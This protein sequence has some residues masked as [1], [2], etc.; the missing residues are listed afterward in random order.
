MRTYPKKKGSEAE[1]HIF[2]SGASSSERCVRYDLLPRE[3]LYRVAKRWDDGAIKHGER[4]CMLGIHDRDYVVDRINHLQEHLN[5]FLSGDT[6]DDNLAAMG[7]G[8]S[9]LMEVEKSVE[10][11]ALIASIAQG[12]INA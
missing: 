12:G 6:T 9:F 10:G 2:T 5:A 11:K 8:I 4:N 1:K 7:W 3:F